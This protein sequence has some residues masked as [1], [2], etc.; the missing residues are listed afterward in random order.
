[1]GSVY[2][3][4][5]LPQTPYSTWDPSSRPRCCETY[6]PP[7]LREPLAR[8]STAANVFELPGIQ[9]KREMRN[10]RRSEGY[11]WTEEPSWRNHRNFTSE[12][13][14]HSYDVIIFT[15]GAMDK[16]KL[17]TSL[18]LKHTHIYVYIYT[19]RVYVYIYSKTIQYYR[20]F[21]KYL[22]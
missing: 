11:P 8:S 9:H 17:V 16:E 15:T 3:H 7:C 19:V 18:K 22:K 10:G 14:G 6:I 21:L 20:E 4:L 1:M 12:L 2:P 13:S 5:L